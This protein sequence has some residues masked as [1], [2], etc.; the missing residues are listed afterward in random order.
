VRLP[1]ASIRR[2]VFAVMLIG[3][4]VVLGLVSLPR[5]GVDLWPRIEFPLV[6]VQ[7]VLPGAAPETMESEVSEVLE[8]AINTIEGIRDLRSFSSDS[9]SLIYIEFELEYDVQEKAQQVREKVAAVRGDLPSDI[10]PPVVDRV[11][12]DA[13]PVLAVLLAGP[14]SIRSLSLLADQR[15]KTRLER[16][17]GVG[18]ATLV[19][20][21]AREIRVWIDPLRLSGYGLAVGEVLAALEREHVELPAG[22][23]ESLERE[24]TL[25]TDTGY[26][27]PDD[28]RRLVVLY[29]GGAFA[30][31]TCSFQR[32]FHTY[33]EIAGSEGRLHINRPFTGMEGGESIVTFY[34]GDG[35]PQVIPVPEAAL[36][37]GEVEDMHAAILDG[38]PGYLKLGE[39]RDHVRTVLALYESARTENIVTL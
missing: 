13:Q 29:P 35:E 5:L 9:L 16:I 3:G 25:R 34:P 39:T 37:L 31:F 22:R 12:P 19:G 6:V 21:R 10:E 4:L 8:E 38:Q 1:D 33:I 20:D 28:F 15:V 2:P 26:T 30:Q 23:L 36:Y 32:P 7:A 11:D 17:R 27:K 18:S 14:Y 24:F